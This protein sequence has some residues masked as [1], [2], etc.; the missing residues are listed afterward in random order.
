V[1]NNRKVRMLRYVSGSGCVEDR[2]KKICELR[3]V[4]LK[5]WERKFLVVF[6]F[7]LIRKVMSDGSVDFEI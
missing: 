1:D 4:I 2:E 7:F 3:I 5:E 6:L